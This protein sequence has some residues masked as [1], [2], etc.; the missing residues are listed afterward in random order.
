MIMLLLLEWEILIVIFYTL[1]FIH[2]LSELWFSELDNLWTVLYPEIRIYIHSSLFILL[3][4]FLYCCIFEFR[5]FSTLPHPLSPTLYTW[6][7]W[8][9]I[10]VITNTMIG[11]LNFRLKFLYS[12][13]YYWVFLFC[14]FG[15]GKEVGNDSWE[16]CF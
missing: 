3:Y 15:L 13:I 16:E 5:E 10:F 14:F 4:T 12:F 1:A 11:L 2:M 6:L 9:A 8:P 7:P